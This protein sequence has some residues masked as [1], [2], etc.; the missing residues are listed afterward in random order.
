[1]PASVKI[2]NVDASFVSPPSLTKTVEVKVP[3]NVSLGSQTISVVIVGNTNKHAKGEDCPN[4][5]L[6]SIKGQ[7]TAMNQAEKSK[8]AEKSTSPNGI[9][10]HPVIAIEFLR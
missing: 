5:L 8:P 2:G 4:N 6:N 9:E 10:L 1:M 7:Y 3:S